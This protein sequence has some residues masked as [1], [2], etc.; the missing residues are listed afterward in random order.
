MTKILKKLISAN[1][2]QV[3]APELKREYSDGS[4]NFPLLLKI[5]FGDIPHC[6]IPHPLLLGNKAAICMHKYA[7]TANPNSYQSTNHCNV[8]EYAKMKGSMMLR[9]ACGD[10]SKFK[11]Q[12]SAEDDE[13]SDLKSLESSVADE[14]DSSDETSTDS[15]GTTAEENKAWN[16]PAF[17]SIPRVV[18]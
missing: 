8:K 9:P 5:D 11:I 1:G 18:G 3:L 16:F 2:N 6:R 13:M 15:M 17:I 12:A 7:A 4:S 10:L 14:S